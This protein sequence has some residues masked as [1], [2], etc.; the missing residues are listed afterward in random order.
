M[1][2]EWILQIRF[3]ELHMKEHS[4]SENVYTNFGLLLLQVKTEL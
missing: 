1:L 3:V 2:R 4:V